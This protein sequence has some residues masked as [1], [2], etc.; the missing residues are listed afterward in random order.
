MLLILSQLMEYSI[1][2]MMMM[3]MW[4]QWLISTTWITPL[5]SVIFPYSEF[6]RI[7]M[8]H[9]QTKQNKL[10]GSSELFVCMFSLSRR[11]Q[12]YRL[13]YGYIKNHKKTIKNGQARTRESEE[14][15]AEARKVK[16][17]HSG[18]NLQFPIDASTLPNADLT[19]DPN[20]PDLEDASDTLPN[21]GILN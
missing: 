13:R 7:S 2:L 11:T 16:S 12:D 18:L 21:D 15:K 5:L 1:E 9:S 17:S 19:I 8:L 4:V 10:Q 14:Y 3:K 20:M 6:I